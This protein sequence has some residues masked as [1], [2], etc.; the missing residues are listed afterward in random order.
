MTWLALW[1]LLKRIPWQ[2]WALVAFVLLVFAAYLY[3]GHKQ[4][5]ADK[6]ELQQ[7]RGQLD[8]CAVV[9]RQQNAANAQAIANANQA[10]AAAQAAEARAGVYADKFAHQLVNITQS[11]AEAKKDPACRQLLETRTCAKLY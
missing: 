10:K 1:Q 6:A 9:V 3:G 4:R 5:Q 2:S 7:L 8:Q 11:L